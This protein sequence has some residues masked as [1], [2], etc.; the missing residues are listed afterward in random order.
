MIKYST[1]ISSKKDIK[2]HFLKCEHSF[3]PALS[4]YVDIDSYTDK[5][6][7]NAIRFEGF[8]EKNLVGLAA[9]YVGPIMY[10][11]NVSIDPDYTNN[12]I[13]KT[14]MKHCIDFCIDSSIKRIELEVYREN[15][16]A[17]SFYKKI[18]F[19][20]IGPKKMRFEINEKRL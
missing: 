10:I 15:K 3:V 20:F 5:I 19:E 14:L 2:N 9:G 13:A 6:F 1:N 18:G 8:C 12:G 11:T 4:S 16:K 7:D 17:I